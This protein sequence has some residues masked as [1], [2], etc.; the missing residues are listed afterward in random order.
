[1]SDIKFELLAMHDGVVMNFGQSIAYIK[2]TPKQAKE[3]GNHLIQLA[4][5]VANKVI[6]TPGEK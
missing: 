6:W 3:I 1:M 4:D 5:E 2:L